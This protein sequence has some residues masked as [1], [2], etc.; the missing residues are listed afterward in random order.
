MSD[1]EWERWTT[2]AADAGFLFHGEGNVSGWLRSL[3]SDALS[4][5]GSVR[6]D[7]GGFDAPSS[8][9]AE[10]GRRSSRPL[11]GR[12]KA[13]AGGSMK[14][15]A[16][17]TS[18][19]ANPLAAT[20]PIGDAANPVAATSRTREPVSAAADPAPAGL[21]ATSTRVEPDVA[22]V[23]IGDPTREEWLRREVALRATFNEEG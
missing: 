21:E 17:A 9:H 7:P 20:S 15:L 11:G 4:I 5:R 23:T 3:A 8:A 19:A 10:P 12:E 18:T 14:T 2:A 13:L 22:Q 1:A 6:T 16:E